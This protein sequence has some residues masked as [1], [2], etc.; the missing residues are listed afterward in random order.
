MTLKGIKARIRECCAER[1]MTQAELA[2]ATGITEAAI[3]RYAGGSRLPKIAQAA[4]IAKWEAEEKGYD[5]N[6][7]YL[8]MQNCHD[9]SICCEDECGLCDWFED[10]GE[11]DETD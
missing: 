8:S 4:R 3:S 2:K 5:C 7:C 1:G 6:D 11:Q 10:I 9:M